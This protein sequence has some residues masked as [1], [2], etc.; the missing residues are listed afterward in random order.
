MAVTCG[1]RVLHWSG[2]GE[3]SFVVFEDGGGG[4]QLV[5]PQQFAQICGP[6]SQLR[7]VFV[8]ACHSQATASNFVRLGV[9]HVVAVRSNA[10]LLDQAAISFTRHFY[11]SLAAGHTVRASFEAA[12]QAVSAMPRR[13]TAGQPAAH[14]SRKFMLLPETPYGQE[15][16][17]H[18]VAI[19][20][21]PPHGGVTDR[22]PPLCASNMPTL[23]ET[24][25]GRQPQMQRAVAALAGKRRCVCLVGAGGIG[26]SALAVA[27]CHLSLIHI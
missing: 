6:A 14:E 21:A 8:C 23:S 18:D 17:P 4:A 9:P 13:L 16:S 7:L 10:E 12:Q 27:V 15:P 19:F 1:T 11:L 22:S 5:T 3:E 26:K 24:F 20:D 25:V 2:H